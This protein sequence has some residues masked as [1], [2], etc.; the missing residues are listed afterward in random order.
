MSTYADAIHKVLFDLERRRDYGIDPNP[1][2]ISRDE[3]RD[4]CELLGVLPSGSAFKFAFRDGLAALIKCGRVADAVDDIG[5]LGLI[6]R[7]K[8]DTY[9]SELRRWEDAQGVKA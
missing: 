2:P 7:D 4:A 3:L 8:P 9:Y 6:T 5:P 1:E